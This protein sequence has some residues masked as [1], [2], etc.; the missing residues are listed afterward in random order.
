MTVRPFEEI[1]A[2]HGS[3]VMRVCRALLVPADAEEAW[4]ETFLSA[5]QAYPRL[6]RDS[7]VRAW[8]VTIAHNKAIDQI[9]SAERRPRPTADLPERSVHDDP[10]TEADGDLRSAVG[11]LPPKQRAAVVYRYLADLSYGEIAVQ[12]ECSEAAARRNAADGIATL[13]QHYLKGTLP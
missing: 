3:V 7:N 9:R 6:R 13:R 10:S 5:M 2:E 8:L 11:S 12:L 1:V 4:S